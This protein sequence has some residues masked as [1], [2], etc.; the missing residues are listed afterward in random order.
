MCA[1]LSLISAKLS[2]VKRINPDSPCLLCYQISKLD[3]FL[4]YTVGTE[5]GHSEDEIIRG[6]LNAALL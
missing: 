6:A 3:F 2:P 4:L 1:L 5:K